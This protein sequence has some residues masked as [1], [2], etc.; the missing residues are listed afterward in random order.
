ML[1]TITPS[2]ARYP[3]SPVLQHCFDNMASDE[4]IAAYKKHC[5]EVNAKTESL[6]EQ[7]KRMK[8]AELAGMKREL[9]EILDV[10]VKAGNGGKVVSQVMM[11]NGKTNYLT[12][13]DLWIGTKK[14]I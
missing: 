1:E 12:V 5:T 10:Q 8:R 13:E 6:R 2:T 3:V 14:Y 7:G 11:Y 9:H 4:V